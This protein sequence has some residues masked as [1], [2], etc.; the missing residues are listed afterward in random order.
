MVAVALNAGEPESLTCTC[1]VMVGLVSKSS[2]DASTTN[3]SPVAGS[4]LNAPLKTL[5]RI[6]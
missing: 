3:T 4:M 6:V 2:T 1:R 5:G